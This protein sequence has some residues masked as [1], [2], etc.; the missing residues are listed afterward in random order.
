MTLLTGADGRAR[1][2]WVGSSPIYLAYHDEEWGRPLHGDHRLYEK[3]TLEAF[4]SGLSWLT[5]LK[6]REGFRAAFAEFD[7]SVVAGFGAAE[8]EALLRDERIIRNRRKIEAAIANAKALVALEA[9]HGDGALDAL[10]WSFAPEPR[11]ESE[12]PRDYADLDASTPESTALAKALKANGFRFVGP[13][14]AYALMQS[15]GLVDDH[16]QGCFRAAA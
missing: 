1:C 8:V 15:G 9:E 2:G 14:T 10:A 12:R 4:Q 11:P 13:T 7:P 16:L 5:I 6:R 3:L